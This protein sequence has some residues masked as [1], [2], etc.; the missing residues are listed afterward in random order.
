MPH[1]SHLCIELPQ[2]VSDKSRVETMQTNYD[3]TATLRPVKRLILVYLMARRG[4]PTF[5]ASGIPP[6][7][8]VYNSGSRY[9]GTSS[10]INAEKAGVSS[11]GLST[12]ALP[13]AMAATYGHFS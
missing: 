9:L 7:M 11:E 1:D 12:Q 5:V 2:N 8:T 10:A 3:P 13:A 6:F 4:I